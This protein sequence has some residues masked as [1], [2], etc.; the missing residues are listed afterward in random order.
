M[1]V[2]TGRTSRVESSFRSK[3][4]HGPALEPSRRIGAAPRDRDAAA[5]RELS[6]SDLASAGRAFPRG[7]DV[8]TLMTRAKAVLA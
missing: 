8:A 1:T 7:V 4:R 6:P 3:R 2:A 5:R